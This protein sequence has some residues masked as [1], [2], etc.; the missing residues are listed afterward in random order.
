VERDVAG[1]A[2]LSRA[3]LEPAAPPPLAHDVQAQLRKLRDQAGERLEGV[4]DLLVRDEARE[5]AQPRCRRAWLRSTKRTWLDTVAHD[6]DEIGTDAEGDQIRP[7]R[8][9]DRDVGG[10]AVQRGSKA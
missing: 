1:H 2:E 8:L 5:D 4:L 9:R 6:A 10:V 7:G 3:F